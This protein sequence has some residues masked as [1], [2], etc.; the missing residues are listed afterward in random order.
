MQFSQDSKLKYWTKPNLKTHKYWVRRRIQESVH[1]PFAKTRIQVHN[2]LTAID[3][4]KAR[5]VGVK[6]FIRGLRKEPSDVNVG[7]ALT[8]LKTLGQRHL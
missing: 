7:D 3:L 4:P 8:I 6:H 1:I 2:C 5:C